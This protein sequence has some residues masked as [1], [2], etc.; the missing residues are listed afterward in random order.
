MERVLLT[1]SSFSPVH[2]SHLHNFQRVKDYHLE[3]HKLSMNVL[4]GYI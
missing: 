4:A 1:T 2:R 3:N